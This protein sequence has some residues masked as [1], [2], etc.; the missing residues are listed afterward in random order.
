MPQF[1]CCTRRIQTPLKSARGPLGYSL[2]THVVAKRF[3]TLSIWQDEV[4]LMSFVHKDPHR[5]NH[6]YPAPSH[7]RYLFRAL[8][9]HR[10][11]GAAELARRYGAIRCTGTRAVILATC[12]PGRTAEL[13]R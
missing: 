8:G 4:S 10:L 3:W 11:G 2:F 9:N 1:F 7:G 12:E 6:G 13:E 5:G